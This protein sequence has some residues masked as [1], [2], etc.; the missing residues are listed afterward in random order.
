VTSALI[1]LFST[2]AEPASRW[3]PGSDVKS[4]NVLLTRDGAAK[5]ADLGLAAAVNE[6]FDFQDISVGHFAY[7]APELV[8]GIECTTKVG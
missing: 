6:R 7:M 4:S 8:L 3:L 1:H 2:S 5:L